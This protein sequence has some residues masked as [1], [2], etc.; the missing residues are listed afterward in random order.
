MRSLALACAVV[1]ALARLARA[2]ASVATGRSSPSEAQLAL[3]DQLIAATPDGAAEKPDLLFRRAI[4]CFA[5]AD[6]YAAMSV[7]D[8]PRLS[9]AWRDEGIKTLL[10]LVDRSEWASYSRMDEALFTLAEQLTRVSRENDARKFLQ[11]LIKSY[12]KS[13]YL[14][15]AY[16]S[17]G[18]LY[19]STGDF[20]NARK[21][22]DKV[23]QY[24]ES[25]IADYARYKVAW[26]A[27]NQGDMKQALASF[28]AVAQH[29][30]DPR[31]Q[32]EAR[33]DAVLVYARIGDRNKA[34]DFF[35]RL[36]PPDEVDGLLER[37]DE[38]LREL[39]K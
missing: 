4:A 21:L 39:G 31:V 24:P 38:A 22:Y 8:A 1:V 15:H 35:A 34:R 17:F 11:K 18:E 20:E 3:L 2:D 37:L 14:P 9:R 23:L 7:A 12:P 30:H 28:V 36:A 33:K 5:L 32:R 10:G 6:Q 27:F 13:R 25:R 26:C 29:G 19:F 16:L